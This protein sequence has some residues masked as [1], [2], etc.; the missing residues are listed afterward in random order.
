MDHEDTIDGVDEVE[1]VID[2]ES[3]AVERRDWLSP[4][5]QALFR[6]FLKTIEDNEKAQ[7]NASTQ[8]RKRTISN[9][10]LEDVERWVFCK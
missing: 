3:P 4:E 1:T 9:A 10:G 8:V 7:A 2:E 6:L 5:K